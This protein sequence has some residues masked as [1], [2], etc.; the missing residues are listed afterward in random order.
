VA[1]L[2]VLSGAHTIGRASCSSFRNRKAENAEFVQNLRRNCT[3][4]LAPPQDLD[5]ITPNTFDNM[6]FS[7]LLAGK[8]VLNSDMALTYNAMT[9][10]IVK[11]FAEDE[12]SFFGTFS[13]AM[14]KM[15]HLEGA[16]ATLGQI[17][18]HCFKVNGNTETAQVFKASA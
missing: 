1:Q 13:N 11:A 6:Y 9:N 8:G 12:G 15:A 14:Q 10:D 4:P 2:V 16:P 3:R 5:V 18:E 7:N 17:R